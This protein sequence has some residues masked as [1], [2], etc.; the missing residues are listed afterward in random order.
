MMNRKKFIFSL[1]LVA[2]IAALVTLYPKPGMSESPLLLHEAERELSL[3]KTSVYQHPTDV[4]EVVGRFNYDCSG[5]LDYALQKISQE[6]YAEVPV[7]KSKRPLAQ[8][9]YTLFSHPISKLSH[10]VQIY[11][12]SRLRAGDVVVWLRPP[13]SDSHNTGHVM[14]ISGK[15]TATSLANERLIPVIDSTSSPHAQDSRHRKQTGLGTGVIGVIVDSQ[16]KAIA[17]RWR[18]GESKQEKETAIAFGRLR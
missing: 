12:V 8:D 3:M 14:V 11:R 15:P 2:I 18:G 16:D 4:D 10:W 9:F 7:S 1:L 6:A 5:F 17:F 13:D